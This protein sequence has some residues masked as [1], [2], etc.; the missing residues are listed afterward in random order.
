MNYWLLVYPRRLQD[1]MKELVAAMKSVCG[2]IGMHVNAP[3]LVELK[4]D[5]IETYVRTIRGL[6]GSEVGPGGSSKGWGAPGRRGVPWGVVLRAL[7][8]LCPAAG[9][10][11]AAALHHQQEQGGFV[12]R[13]QE[14]V[15]RADPGALA[16]GCRTKQ[17]QPPGW[18]LQPLFFFFFPPLSSS[19]CRSSTCSP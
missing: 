17:P 3:A 6:L 4:D 7:P 13:H 10:G 18:L 9:Q 15:L 5:R 2:P 16:G 14:A 19:F 8:A 11:A 1:L 12:Q